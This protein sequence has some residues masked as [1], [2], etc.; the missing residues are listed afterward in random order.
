MATTK[1]KAPRVGRVGSEKPAEEV[2]AFVAMERDA[3]ASGETD[4][5]RRTDRVAGH[6]A[7]SLAQQVLAPRRPQ[8]EAVIEALRGVEA[9]DEAWEVLAAR[10][11]IPVDWLSAGARQVTVTG[12]RCDVCTADFMGHAREC[13]LANVPATVAAAAT[14]AADPAGI[15]A[16]ETLARLCFE[17]LYGDTAA[18]EPRMLW[19]V[20]AS[21]E[22]SPLGERRPGAAK[23]R[24]PKPG[25]WESFG[26]FR[27][28][29]SARLGSV[30]PKGYRR[31]KD[32]LIVPEYV[33]DSYAS[34]QAKSPFEVTHQPWIHA[35]ER[36]AVNQWS[37]ALSV[38]EKRPNPFTPLCEV[39]A[40]GYAVELVDDETL[41]LFAPALR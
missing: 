32:G 34:Y 20:G 3:R 24:A 29:F 13:E 19:R 40:L 25:L 41:L 4:D 16:A 6:S 36:D 15:S 8:R 11:L 23:A 7:E 30:L 18:S 5:P 21:D 37:W 9:P 33:S 10:E 26:A 31:W 17:R 28:A 2:P 39:W 27:K 1:K 12:V 14:L 35:L 38:R 22:C